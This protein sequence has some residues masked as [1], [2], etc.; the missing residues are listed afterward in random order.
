M[1]DVLNAGTGRNSA[2]QDKF[3]RAI[4]PRRFDLGFANGLMHKDVKLCVEEAA[5]L[6][7]PMAVAEAVERVWHRACEE[8]GPDGDFS[9]IIQCIERDAGIEVT[10][11][12]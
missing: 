10:G 6:G 2:T 11:K 1:L 7:V 12:G 3:A 4:L 9:T 5:A 8:N